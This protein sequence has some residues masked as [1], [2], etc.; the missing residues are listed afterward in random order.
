MNNAQIRMQVI[1]LGIKYYQ[2]ADALGWSE[3][4]LSRLLRSP[5]QDEDRIAIEKAIAQIAKKQVK[6][7]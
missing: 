5:L 3:S 4:K 2:I 6:V 1:S 7:V